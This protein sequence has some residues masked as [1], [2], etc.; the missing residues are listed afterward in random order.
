[1]PDV[2]TQGTAT[3]ASPSTTTTTSPTSRP[4]GGNPFAPAD[5]APS[6]G[7]AP[8][9]D[10]LPNHGGAAAPLNAPPAG[11]AAPAGAVP[12][13]G[14]GQPPQPSGDAP[15]ANGQPTPT[16]PAL[17]PETIKSIVEA[18]VRGALPQQPAQ[19]AAQP[20]QMTQEEFNRHYGLP[21]VDAATYEAI[22]GTGPDKPER[23]QALQS[24]LH[25]STRAA[26]LMAQELVNNHLQS[27]RGELGPVFEAHRAQREAAI[28]NKFFT[29]FP[30]FK[31][32]EALINEIK[33]AFI[34][35]KASF[36]SEDEA[37]AAVATQARQ[38]IARFRQPAANGQPAGGTQTNKGGSGQP[39]ARTMTPSSQGGRGGTGAATSKP[40]AE[41]IFG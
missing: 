29:K 23:A 22:L 40:I 24:L 26:V 37:F 36:A 39:P 18:S 19:P 21:T 11:D 35:R 15:P 17:T 12:P 3:P 27:L 25:Q 20:K 16:P 4:T 38:I 10:S 8:S 7:G 32:E 33:D 30:E 41:Q 14:S 5:N 2:P 28:A 9:A 13:A 1:M 34:A 31:G 6:A